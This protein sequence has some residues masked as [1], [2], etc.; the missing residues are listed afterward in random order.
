[1]LLVSLVGLTRQDLNNL[2]CIF[3]TQKTKPSEKFVLQHLMQ[4]HQLKHVVTHTQIVGKISSKSKQNK[5]SLTHLYKCKFVLWQKEKMN[6]GIFAAKLSIL[7]YDQKPTS[8]ER[9]A[10]AAIPKNILQN[11]KIKKTT[12]CKFVMKKSSGQGNG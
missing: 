9:N 4:F 8:L 3:I 7:C 1:M 12:N 5:T 10:M 11:S 2:L 6:I